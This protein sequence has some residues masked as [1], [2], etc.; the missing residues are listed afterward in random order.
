[1]IVAVAQRRRGDE[2]LS[3]RVAIRRRIQR[4]DGY[5]HRVQPILRNLEIRE[6]LL[7]KRIDRNQPAAGEIAGTLGDRRHGGHLGD[8][9][10]PPPA[11]VIREE[12]GTV[13]DDRTAGRRAELVPLI[14]RRRLLRRREVIPRIE[15]GIA[16]VLVSRAVKLV[17]ARAQHH[18]DLT[19][20]VTTKRSIVGAGEH[21]ELAYGIHRWTHR[22]AV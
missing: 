15:D 11:L 20:T 12:E 2:V 22:R 14:L 1:M 6:R 8:P 17:P 9:R 18:A 3:R 7:R 4:R 5:A 21:L 16:E 10:I 13:P 19:P